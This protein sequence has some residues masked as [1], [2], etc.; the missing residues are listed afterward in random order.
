MEGERLGEGEKVIERRDLER[1]REKG[2]GRE[3][4]REC[5]YVCMYVC[6]CIGKRGK[7][8]ELCRF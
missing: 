1:E 4:G 5:V 6:P 2:R 7:E 8:L 3:G